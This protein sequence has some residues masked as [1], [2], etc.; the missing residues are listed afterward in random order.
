DSNGISD[1]FKRQNGSHQTEPVP[2]IRYNQKIFVMTQCCTKFMYHIH[3]DDKAA[4]VRARTSGKI[5]RNVKRQGQ[6]PHPHGYG[7]ST[8]ASAAS[9][10]GSQKVMAIAR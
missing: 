3:R 9:V 10:S 2:R 6:M 1:D 5:G 8:C 7:F 4:S